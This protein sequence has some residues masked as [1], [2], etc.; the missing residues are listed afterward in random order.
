MRAVQVAPLVA[1]RAL[2][3]VFDYAVPPELDVDVAVG[4][5]VAVPLGRRTVL[6]LVTGDEAPTWQGDLAPL[7]GLVDAPAVA[8]PL[9][10]LAGWVARYYAA[11]VAAALRLVLPFGAEGALRRLPG[12][13]WR[14]ADPPAPP[15]RLVASSPSQGGSARQREVAGVLRAAGG[16][17]PAA[18]LCRR[19]GTTMATL[20]RM[21]AARLID[22]ADQARYGAGT[23][24]PEPADVPPVL[25]DD[26]QAAVGAIRHGL[27]TGQEAL[28]IH[29]VTGSGKTEVYLH[30]IQDARRRGRGAIVLAPEIALTPQLL[31]RLRARLGERVAIWHS[32]LSDGERAAEHARVRS[33]Q[34]DVV[35][36]ARSAVFAPVQRLGLI[37]VDEEHEGTYKQDTVPRYDARQVA[38]RRGR[39]ESALVVYG[40]A[41][42]R[43]ESWSAIPRVAL[44]GRVDDIPM[45][46]VELV[47]MRMQAPGPLSRPLARALQEAAGRGDKAILLLN[48]RGLARMALC[49]ACG[50]IGRCP[51]CD[52]PLVV[53]GRPEHLICHHCGQDRPVPDLCPSCGAAEVGRSGSG[54][55]GLEEA[56]AQVVPD[57][58]LIR[59]DADAISRRGELAARLERFGRP[60]AAILL[61]TQMVAKGH[62]LPDITVAAV[63]DADGPLQQPDFRAEERAFG[64]I[65]QLA[66]RAGRRGEPSTVYVQAWEPG[67][68]AV[69]LGARHAVEEFLDG[70]IARRRERGFPPF[71]HL[72]RAVVHGEQLATVT[73]AARRLAD[74]L[75]EASSDVTVYGPAPL[76][77]LRGR[78]RRSVLLR[79]DH[80]S[81]ATALLLA[82]IDA[83]RGTWTRAGV[84]VSVDVD[85]QDT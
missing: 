77:R 53:H 74:D 34:A 33:G 71:G 11:P 46:H 42:P 14:L 68:R 43:P 67:G 70:E 40:T 18:E 17:M 32:G 22:L 73:A 52:V 51:R 63:L 64:L 36:G 84:A 13:G 12:G 76:H 27:D 75:R 37:V 26:Q 2:E 20:R 82:L 5:L 85:P 55:Q 8:A 24:E 66:G 7:A 72:V 3:R 50:W 47:D 48:R 16:E 35:V 62:D 80:A 1:A 61:G 44:P 19:A 6:G 4:S 83:A 39:L 57:V 25:N 60:G 65:V 45:P 23:G 31:R 41:T 56:L 59:L 69:R 30:A 10:E 21:A 49:R 58:P 79:A 29:G 78:A 38:Y 28:L 54:T 9:V 15:R 81:P